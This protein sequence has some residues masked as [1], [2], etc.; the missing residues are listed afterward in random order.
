M[1]KLSVKLSVAVLA[2]VLAIA[3]SPYAMTLSTGT[4]DYRNQVIQVC[5]I[6][7]TENLT[8]TCTRAQ[9]AQML[10]LASSQKDII[11]GSA[12]SAAAD[13]PGSNAYAKY[14]RLALRNNWMR[15]RLSG[16][17][18]PDGGLTLNDASK[19]AMTALGYIDNDFSENVTEERLAKFCSLGL[20]NGVGAVTGVDQLTKQEAINVIYNML[21]ANTKGSQNIYGSAINLTLASDGEL[22]ATSVLDD[23]MQGPVLIKAYNELSTSLPFALSEA[24]CYYN[25]S[26][27]SYYS[28]LQLLSYS[29]QLQ[30]SGW[31][32]IYYNEASKTVWG[33][34]TDS[35]DNAYHCVRG[36]VNAIY[37]DS[38]NIVSPTS[39]YVGDTLYTLN[40]ADVKFMFSVNGT[41]GVGDEVIL[42]C[43][44]NSGGNAM[45]GETATSYYAT[46]V[47]LYRKKGSK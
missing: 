15:T 37:Y 34:G 29:S 31:L 9:F 20:N 8:E 14:I 7:D 32:I 26:M 47:V 28:N 12:I 35:G 24:T 23:T 19:A 13:V 40:S 33:Y 1:K 22:N 25:G 45:E 30:N 5:G 17:F 36:T 21:K 4:Q 44:G 43:K 18:D 27:T 2:M 16:N 3:I 39:V 41:I 42:I 38:D 46:G 6:S 11:G 10:I